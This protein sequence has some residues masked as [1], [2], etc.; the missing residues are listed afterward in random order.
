MAHDEQPL[1]CRCGKPAAVVMT[2][3]TPINQWCVGEWNL[4]E[5]HAWEAL[6]GAGIDTT[7]EG[8]D[9]TDTPCEEE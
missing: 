4:C 6:G 9:L 1:L 5:Y 2:M 3:T 8:I 7:E